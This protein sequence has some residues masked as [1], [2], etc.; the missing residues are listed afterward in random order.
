M[1]ASS[2]LTTYDFVVIAILLVFLIR[3]IMVG[4]LRQI[5]FFAALYFSYFVASQH[6]GTI[7]PYLSALSDNP[8]VVFIISY[9]LLFITAYLLFFFL[10]KVLKMVVQVSIVSFFDRILGAVIGLAKAVLLL[11]SIHMILG[12]ML[13]PENRMLRECASCDTL[14]KGSE[15]A[16]GIIKD[17]E[18]RAAL[19]SKKPAIPLDKVKEYLE[20]LTQ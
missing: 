17:P 18:I 13:A 11:V 14:N 6:A 1:D 12:T 4:F 20:P 15:A 19:K 10:G 9:V 5:S 3:G 8:K 2:A 16:R 7:E